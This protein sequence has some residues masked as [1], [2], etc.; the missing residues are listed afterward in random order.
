MRILGLL[1][2]CIR[3]ILIW[4]TRDFVLTI[5]SSDVGC[6]EIPWESWAVRETLIGDLARSK[7][8]PSMVPSSISSTTQTM[9]RSTVRTGQA[10]IPGVIS[11]SLGVVFSF[12][13]WCAA[14][15]QKNRFSA[16]SRAVMYRIW[17]ARRFARIILLH[18]LRR[19]APQEPTEADGHLRCA[20]LTNA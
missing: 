12:A 1:G 13:K 19:R 14:T 3:R 18:V 20:N 7:V 10:C 5:R 17:L 15:R 4:Y 9:T 11:E 8:L 16:G 2:F 6:P